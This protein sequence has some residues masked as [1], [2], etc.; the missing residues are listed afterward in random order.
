MYQFWE[1]YHPQRTLIE[2]NYA[3]TLMGDEVLKARARAAG[4]LLLPHKTH[5]A[6]RKRGSIND[7]EYGIAAVAPLLRG[8]LV[9]LPSATPQDR[10]RLEPLI[11][12]M[13]AF[14]YSDTKD[15]LVAMWIAEGEV[16][17]VA[18]APPE[19][20]NVIAARNLPPSIARRLRKRAQTFNS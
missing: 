17:S 16:S 20:D 3:P 11:S 4:T 6:G 8:G 14:P 12:D 7:E 13:Q 9:R 19:V 10:K 5:G 15:A 2:V 1:Q 18:A